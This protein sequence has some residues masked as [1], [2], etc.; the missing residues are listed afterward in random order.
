MCGNC[1]GCSR[2]CIEGPR[3][4]QGVPG[5]AGP[6][7]PAGAAGPAGPQGEPGPPGPVADVQ[8]LWTPFITGSTGG[9]ATTVNVQSD[10]YKVGKLV[11]CNINITVTSLVGVS[12]QIIINGLPYLSEPS[13]SFAGSLVVAYY[14]NFAASSKYPTGQVQPASNQVYMFQTDPPNRNTVPMT[15]T[16]IGPNGQIVG[17][18]LYVTS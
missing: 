10:Y 12:G 7:G 4:P 2:S 8:G 6:A 15:V 5:V 11:F 9:T 1:N 17:T 3:G 13:A 14:L 16:D 18:I